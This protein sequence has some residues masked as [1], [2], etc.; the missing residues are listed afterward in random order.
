MYKLFKECG[1]Q[2]LLKTKLIYNYFFRLVH[3]KMIMQTHCNNKLLLLIILN[4]CLEKADKT[5]KRK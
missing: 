4:I 2:G 3:Y 5:E 1:R